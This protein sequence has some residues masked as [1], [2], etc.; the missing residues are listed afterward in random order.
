M[1]ADVHRTN[2]SESACACISYLPRRDEAF[3]IGRSG[4][5]PSSE[6]VMRNAKKVQALTHAMVYEVINRAGMM[7]ESRDGGKDDSA[8][9]RGLDHIAQVSQMERR[10]T[11]H[12]N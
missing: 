9:L 1:D 12:Q 11:H 4:L 3:A 6:E 5:S 7:V 2:A 8:H 10:L